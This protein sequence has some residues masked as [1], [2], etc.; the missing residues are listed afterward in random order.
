MTVVAD[1]N[2]SLSWC[3]SKTIA[4]KAK[5]WIWLS[6]NS[7]RMLPLYL[8]M[9]LPPIA[10]L[11]FPFRVRKTG[12]GLVVSSFPRH[13]STKGKMG[14]L[15]WKASHGEYCRDS[16][17]SCTFT[18]FWSIRPLLDDTHNTWVLFRSD[19]FTEENFRKFERSWDDGRV[20]TAFF[21]GTAT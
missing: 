3:A 11:T 12:K 19:L 14:G 6:T 7:R 20:A 17:S 16:F 9:R 13:S 4:R 1:S 5:M 8:S 15:K 2:W 18:V 10:S 21:R